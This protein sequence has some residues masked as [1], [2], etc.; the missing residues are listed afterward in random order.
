[1]SKTRIFLIH[2]WG[3]SPRGDWFPWAKTEMENRGYVVVAPQMP[4]TD[5]PTIPIWID[6]L[7]EL[8]GDIRQSDIF[9]GHS[10]GCQTIM[11]YLEKTNG[12]VAK[13]VLVAPWFTLTNLKSAESWRLAD[14]WIKSPMDFSQIKSKSNSFITIFSDND[15][16]VPYEE[17]R[18]MFLEKLNPEIITLHN[19]GHMTAEEGVL[20]LP[21]ILDC[22]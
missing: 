7:S 6:Y 13:V 16:W 2:G 14:P 18:Q 10:I 12:K 8:A 1:M 17:N 21:K 22:I 20:K 19:Q 4:D 5:S 9:I 3:G 15:P 11:R